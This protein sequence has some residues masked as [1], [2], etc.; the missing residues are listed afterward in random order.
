MKRCKLKFMFIAQ[1]ILALFC[2]YVHVLNSSF[3]ESDSQC[4]GEPPGVSTFVW[5]MLNDKPGSIH[6]NSINIYSLKLKIIILNGE[7]SK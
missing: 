6:F 7:C 5:V 4:L 2:E 1:S 3:Q